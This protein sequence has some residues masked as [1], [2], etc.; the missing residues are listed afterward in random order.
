VVLVAGDGPERTSLQ[1]AISA[2]GVD[3]RLLGRRDDIADLLSVSDVVVLPSSW[4][5]RPLVAQEALAA[6]RALVTTAAGGTAELVGDA[7]VFV[8]VG[9][10]AA[11]ATAVAALLDDPMRRQDLE[12]RAVARAAQWPTAT[13]VGERLMAVYA[14]LVAKS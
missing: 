12:S 10:V 8:P 4:E 5:A 6:G 14:E 3:V 9:D 11:L 2:L 7:A 1:A 13:E